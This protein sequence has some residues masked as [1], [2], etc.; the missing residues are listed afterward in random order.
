[1]ILSGIV[2]APL[3][4]GQ[5]A[6]GPADEGYTAGFSPVGAGSYWALQPDGVA[7]VQ[8]A[9]AIAAQ[10]IDWSAAAVFLLALPA[11]GITLSPVFSNAVPGQMVTLITT[12]GS[13]P[14]TN[15]WTNFGG[16]S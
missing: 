10:P 5:T 12:Q 13:T 6:S 2:A 7:A 3:V 8:T 15:N 14:S 9:T 16:T 1:M 11:A 4:H